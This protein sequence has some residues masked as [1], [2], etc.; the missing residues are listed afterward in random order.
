MKTFFLL[1]LLSITSASALITPSSRD[2]FASSSQGWRIG[3]LGIQPARVAAAGPEGQIGYMSHLSD[4]GGASGKW[5]M[6]SDE[7]QWRG[8]YL[9][10]GVTAISLWANVSAGSNPVSMRIAFD[11][12]GGWFASSAQSVGTGW[13]NYAFTLAPANFNHVTASGGSGL[14]A[15]TFSGVTRFEI[16]AGT[17]AVSYRSGGDIVQAGNS[18]N[19]ILLD[20]ISAVPEPSTCAPLFVGAAGACAFALRR[21]RRET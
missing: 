20:N 15:D 10:A 14:F 8:D 3:S 13:A 4:G 12:P 1:S 18:V 9:S 6:W 7:S 19:T 16:L 5:L 17:G 11:G 21:A 2:D